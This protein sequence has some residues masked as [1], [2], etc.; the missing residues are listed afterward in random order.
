MSW[1]PT[2]KTEQVTVM[3][4]SNFSGLGD[5]GGVVCVLNLRCWKESRAAQ[6]A[7]RNAD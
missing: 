6:E 5:A 4:Q 3:V 7:L 1:R 2:E